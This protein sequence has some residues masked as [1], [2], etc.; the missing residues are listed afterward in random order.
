VIGSSIFLQLHL[1]L[2][3]YLGSAARHALRAATGPAL[4]VI[5]V[6]IAGSILVWVV[7]RGRRAGAGG[8]IE[9]ACPACMALALVSEQQRELRGVVGSDAAGA[10]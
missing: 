4:A 6:L 7:R 8:L 1:F 9:A 5:A 2:G 10:E 3:Y